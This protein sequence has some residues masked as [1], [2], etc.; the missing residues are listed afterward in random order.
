MNAAMSLMVP[1]K[2]GRLFTN[3]DGLIFLSRALLIDQG[4]CHL[5]WPRTTQQVGIKRCTPISWRAQLNDIGSLRANLTFR[6]LFASLSNLTW[7][8]SDFSS[9]A[10]AEHQ[11]TG[12][13]SRILSI[14]RGDQPCFKTGLKL[15]N[16]GTRNKMVSTKQKTCSRHTA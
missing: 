6:L 4:T 11:H 15:H 12:R 2:A 13:V 16:I 9:V 1:E 8:S 3:W 10:N 7:P 14:V 5:E